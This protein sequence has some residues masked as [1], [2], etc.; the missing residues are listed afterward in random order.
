MRLL[1]RQSNGK[2]CLT[3]KFLPDTTPPYAILSHT[4]GDDSQ[5]LTYEDLSEGTGQRKSG[6]KKLLFCAEQAAKDGL[7]H[8]WVDTCC[9]KKS[10]DAELSSSINSMFRW[11]QRANKC[12][13][14]LSDVSINENEDSHITKR[15]EQAFRKSRWFTRG[16]TL[17]ELLAPASVE[18]FSVEGQRL[19]DRISLK[20]QIHEITGIA[21]PALEGKPLH[22]FAV[23]ERNSW[24][25]NRVTTI[26]ED[27][28]YC[29]IGI[30]DVSMSS[31]YG[32]GKEKAIERL[33]NK[34]RKRDDATASNQNIN[35]TD[36]VDKV[37]V[38]AIIR[39]LD[40]PDHYTNYQ[41]ALEQRQAGTGLWFLQHESYQNWIAGTKKFFWLHGIA[42]C[43]KSILSSTIIEDLL[44]RAEDISS[45]I[46]YFYFDFNDPQKRR[47]D[48]MVRSIMAQLLRQCDDISDTVADLFLSCEKG[49]RQP[50][51]KAYLE[52]L[53]LTISQIPRVF[54]VLDA[55][56]ECDERKEL[57]ESIATISGWGLD[58]LHVLLTS[59][60]E[61]DIEVNVE[62]VVSS[63]N[64]ISLQSDRVDPDIRAYIV[65]RL[66]EDRSLEKWARSKEVKAEIEGVLMRKAHG[67][68]VLPNDS[69][70]KLIYKQVSMGRL[71]TGRTREVPQSCTT[72]KG[73]QHASAHPRQDIRK[74]IMCNS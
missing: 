6:Y 17:Q 56:D 20:T 69:C 5:E 72:S 23:S 40:P 7:H 10:S 21:L 49:N 38:D 55:L 44:K 36:V 67:M 48:L 11:Y 60:R 9:I 27:M 64:V 73:T 16:W 41:I 33:N 54:L 46:V 43:G 1:T 58:D 62:Q 39:W 31:R 22:A 74:D 65:E 42:G 51:L 19:G 57:L 63:E 71:P 68:Y 61:R 14:F 13:A 53:R 4:W 8:F 59:R 29:L 2:L 12:Y 32:E 30:F 26:D 47:T 18:F 70:K 45:T 15:W 50:P 24:A 35:G 66:S 25:A 34:I 3:R 37:T 28:A 52:V